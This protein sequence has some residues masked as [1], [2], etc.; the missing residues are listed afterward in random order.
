MVHFAW[1]DRAGTGYKWEMNEWA[2]PILG[3]RLCA[4]LA[5]GKS[6]DGLDS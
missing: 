6:G 4:R 5:N 3:I 2:R 1:F